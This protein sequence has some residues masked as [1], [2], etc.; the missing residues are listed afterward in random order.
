MVIGVLTGKIIDSTNRKADNPKGQC[1]YYCSDRC[2][3]YDKPVAVA[4]EEAA[5]MEKE[6]IPPDNHLG[7][8][9]GKITYNGATATTVYFAIFSAV[10]SPASAM[11]ATLAMSFEFTPF[12]STAVSS[13]PFCPNIS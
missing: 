13:T 9:I 8:S 4:A 1:G 12:A 7:R 5:F 11:T 3:D 6:W 10:M 2:L